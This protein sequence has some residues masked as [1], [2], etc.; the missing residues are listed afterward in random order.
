MKSQASRDTAVSD[1]VD[2]VAPTRRK[3]YCSAMVSRRVG[4]FTLFASL[5]T[6]LASCV[7]IRVSSKTTANDKLQSLDPLQPGDIVVVYGDN[8]PP[9]EEALIDYVSSM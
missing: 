9:R 5:L 6:L 8:A 2:S 3:K 1:P 4:W 7:A